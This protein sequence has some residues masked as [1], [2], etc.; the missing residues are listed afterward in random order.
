MLI[1]ISK[2]HESF[3]YYVIEIMADNYRIP[4]SEVRIL[5]RQFEKQKLLKRLKDYTYQVVKIKPKIIE[6]P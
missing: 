5:T 4:K 2:M 6:K 1:E 3:P